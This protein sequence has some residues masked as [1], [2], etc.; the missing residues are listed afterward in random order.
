[1]S[2]VNARV[3][4]I[5]QHIGFGLGLMCKSRCFGRDAHKVRIVGEYTC[6]L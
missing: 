6:L 5:A 4:N 3:G 1:M 2:K